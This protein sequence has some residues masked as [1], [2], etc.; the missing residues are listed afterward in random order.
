MITTKIYT[1]EKTL[2]FEKSYWVIPGK[3]MAGQYPAD[4]DKID[5]LL[6]LGI[7][8]F[9]NLTLE[10]ETSKDGEVHFDYETQLNDSDAVMYRKEVE[11]ASIPTTEIMDEISELIDASLEDNKPVYFHCWGG[12]GRTGTVLGSYLMHSHMANKDN[13][14]DLIDYMKRTSPFKEK[15]SPGRDVQREFVVNYK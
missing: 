12:V 11:D 1:M 4:Q 15:R 5:S 7:K 13:V 6:A 3:I 9:I 14:F 8:T 10:G 2:P